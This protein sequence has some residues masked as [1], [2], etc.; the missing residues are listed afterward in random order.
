MSF[1]PQSSVAATPAV[2]LPGMISDSGFKDVISRLL[3]GTCLPGRFVCGDHENAS[4]PD[5]A[6]DVTGQGLGGVAYEPLSTPSATGFADG[7]S[8][9]I[10]RQGRL[11]LSLLAGAA[12]TS[13]A[14]VYVYRGATAANRGLITQ[15]SA[16]ADVTR[17]EGAKF[18]G[19]T[20]SG[21]AEVQLD[22]I[23]VPGDGVGVVAS[24]LAAAANGQGASLV[25]IE[26]AGAFTTATTV[27]GATAEI[28]QDLKSTLAVM[29]IPLTSFLDADGDPL[30][31]FVSAAS[32]TFGFALADSE[33]LCLRWNN[34]ANP[35]TALCQIGLPPDL[36]DTADAY[37]EFLCSKSGATVG[38]AT[39]LTTTAFLIKEGDLH[40]ADANAG[41]VT[42]ALVGNAAAKTTDVL[43]RTI[44]AA[45][46]E[47]D[48]LSMTLTVTPT[49]G[50]LGTDDL[51][52]HNVRLRYKRKLRAS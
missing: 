32:P 40:D 17:A 27:E 31:K 21:I 43:S 28:Y 39:T 25:G 19:R 29:N 51:L 16:A 36:D 30:A 10:V 47:P 33:A 3:L 52:I 26:D 22:G 49:A 18:T 23:G 14:A 4:V 11:W 1:T 12:P 8:V 50:L 20:A 42:N 6:A 45:D 15:N 41:G 7:Y 34:D 48:A 2:A 35:G 46:I 24:E 38:D 13:G 5:A 9:S 37:L 44:A